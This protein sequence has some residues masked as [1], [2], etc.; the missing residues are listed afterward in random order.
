M[1]LTLKNEFKLTNDGDDWGNVMAWLFAIGD[2]ITF[3]TDEYIPDSWQFKPSPLG[4][5]EDCFVY[6]S[7]RHFAF[8][9]EIT[10]ADVLEFGKILIR[11]RDILERKGESY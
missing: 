9:G 7:L 2:Y 8:E 4:A 5:N 10:N 11:V 6:Q 1:N 3:D